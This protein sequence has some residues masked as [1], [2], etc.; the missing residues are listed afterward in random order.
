MNSRRFAHPAH[1]Q[2]PRRAQWHRRH[3]EAEQ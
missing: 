3:F 2:S 1:I